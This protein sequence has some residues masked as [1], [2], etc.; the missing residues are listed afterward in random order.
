MPLL[1]A[2][3]HSSD[4]SAAFYS[5]SGSGS[6]ALLRSA[7]NAADDDAAGGGAGGRSRIGVGTALRAKAALVRKRRKT[8][9][10]DALSIDG[11]EKIVR[12]VQWARTQ[13]ANYDAGL[14]EFRANR[15]KW[16]EEA[17][18]IF[19]HRAVARRERAESGM[20]AEPGCVFEVLNESLNVVA[21]LAEFAAAQAEQDIYGGEPWFAARPVG[22]HDPALAEMIQKHLQWTFRD[23]RLVDNHCLGIDQC[24]TLGECF[25]KTLYA[26]DVDSYEAPVHCL[27]MD[28][29]PVL[30]AQGNHV[31]TDA[32]AATL[33]KKLVKGKAEWKVA[34][35]RREVVIRQGV[36]TIPI[37]YADISFRVDAPELDLR[38]TNVFVSVEMSVF[39]AMRRFD[40]SKEDA[41][42]LARCAGT[43]SALTDA[44]R[45][46]ERISDATAGP[47]P[48]E[49]PLG[50]L[51][52]ERLLNTR[53]RLIEGYIRA[54][55][56]GEGRESRM[57]IVFPPLQEDWIIWGDYLA[58][59]SPRA[60]LPIKVDVWSPVPHR[61]YGRGFFA[62]YSYLQTGTD[63]LWNQVNFR[64]G[65]HANPLVAIHRDNLETDEDGGDLL[66][67]P[68]VS[69]TP[70]S[71]KRLADCIESFALPDGDNRSMELL[72][73]GM[74]IAQ[75]RS[76]ITSASQ[77]DLSNVPESNTATGIRSLMS[78]AAVLLKKPIR[79]LR[80]SK[81]RALS[82][83]VRLL[84]AN[85]DRAEAFV[86]GEGTNRALVTL[87]PEHVRD[88]D[89]DVMMLM[90][91][92]QNQTKLQG[93][94][95]MM[96]LQQQY[97]GLPEMD[98]PGARIGVVQAF[99]ALEFAQAEEMVRKPVVSIE[100]CLPLLPPEE[101]AKLQQAM[102]LL[103]QM[104][105][106]GQGQQPQQ[107]G[108]AQPGM[109]PQMQAGAEQMMQA[110]QEQR[111]GAPQ[112]P[113]QQP[114]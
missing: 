62:I 105:Q 1:P 43:R 14:V 91:Q 94:Q 70:K 109:P 44:E 28:G 32:Q 97:A 71:G 58:N 79:R 27:H 42:R 39:E 46:M 112:G 103:Q 53:V 80:R 7:A 49:E 90:T 38:Y 24:V 111:L 64:N 85:F 15:R 18:D 5:A 45:E 25:T 69:I 22:K 29:K 95:V 34:Y 3:P 33:S 114:A 63:N 67:R 86:F 56:L 48:E 17:Q 11:G 108:A 47:P 66:I 54:D 77:G 106:A 61:L 21:G 84:Y 96:Q 78:R 16:S 52:C 2:L 31:T 98:K 23:G 6:P 102:A 110:Q 72:Q 51:E 101:G 30:D 26:V 68:G 107:E 82:Y 93:A 12:L 74:Q 35:E 104:M 65:M 100:S 55:A 73:I 75:L 99:K 19:S 113:Q 81:G 4:S 13:R 40:L 59:V 9:L 36:E 57:C 83:A 89:V 92:E 20:G 50:E 10:E 87:T 60:E 37:H 88:L 76:G 8:P 41:I